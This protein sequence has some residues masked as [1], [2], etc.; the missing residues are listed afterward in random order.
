VSEIEDRESSAH[1][2]NHISLFSLYHISGDQLSSIIG[3]IT[4]AYSGEKKTREREQI[5][6]R[7]YHQFCEE[8]EQRKRSLSDFI[9]I[10]TIH[11]NLI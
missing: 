10:R 8:G 5:V 9:T 1:I 7:S 4:V 11:I 3:F 6:Q 2:V